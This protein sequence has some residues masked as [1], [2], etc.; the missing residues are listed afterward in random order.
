MK[1]KW[2]MTE[3]EWKR[4]IDEHVN[5]KDNSNNVYGNLYV[6]KL[7]IDFCHTKDE[8]AWY[9]YVSVFEIGKDTGYG[10]TVEGNVPYDLLDNEIQIPVKCKTFDNFKREIEKRVKQMVITD[11][12]EEQANAELAEW[13]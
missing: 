13:N 12:L 7:C 10:Y 5:H 6:G 9:L 3:S 2:D 8:S 1:F 4:M 11:G